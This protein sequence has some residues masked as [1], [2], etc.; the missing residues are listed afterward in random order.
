MSDCCDSK[1]PPKKMKCP[2]CEQSHK[3][4]ANQVLLHHVISPDNQSIPD[5]QFYFCTSS[6]CETVYFSESGNR[7]HQNQVRATVGQKQTSNDRP[8]C[9]CFDVTAQ[10]VLDELY[11]SGESHSK[12]FVTA[13]TKSKNCACDIRN[14][15][16]L[17]C[18]ASFP[19]D[20]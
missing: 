10:Q 19:S 5:K 11:Q 20:V 6:D 16:G 17:C 1:K 14:P 9:Y 7:Y 13:Q 4:V 2:D 3:S 15:S 8:I 18:L 12:A